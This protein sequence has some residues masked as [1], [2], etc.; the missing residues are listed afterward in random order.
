ML[1]ASVFRL[2]LRRLILLLA[3]LSSLATLGISFYASYQVQRQL[4]IDS[5]LEANRTYA[6]KLADSTEK[7][8]RSAQQQLRFSAA[9]L[10]RQLD[11]PRMVEAEAQR[12]NEQTNSFNSIVITRDDG[13]VLATAPA[14]LEIIG[15]QLASPGALEA[16][17]E[18][19]PMISKPYVSAAGNLVVFISQ[20]IMRDEQYLGYVGGTIYL[21][22]EN[23]LNSLLGEHHYQDGSYLYAVDGDRRLLYH[24]DAARV[25]TIVTNNQ[26]I[27]AVVAGRS[28]SQRV[29]NSQGVDMLAGYAVVPIA[30]WGIVAQRPTASTLVELND[31]M[32]GVL[33]HT[34]F[35]VALVLLCIWALA[36]LI[37]RPLWQLAQG[38]SELDTPDISE[39]I[40][41]VP[42]WYFETAQL[43]RALL[44]GIGL[45][46]QKIGR[47]HQ[48]V[49]TDPL[50][51]L[52]NR[53]GMANA[54]DI[55]QAQGNP[56]AVVALDI[57][58]FKRINDGHGHAAGDAV[59]GQ[60]AELMRSASRSA[61][62]LCRYGGEEFLM[63]LPEADID[64]A[65]LVAERLRECVARMPCIEPVTISI[66]VSICQPAEQSVEQA[67]KAADKALYQ[68]KQRGRNRLVIAED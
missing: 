20:P 43:K 45:L 22:Q 2:D 51:G 15:Q 42:S 13:E 36:R 35:P 38:A 57:D 30:G 12:L 44:L 3:I 18:R 48:D 17:G 50:T 27:D 34:A 39:R 4:L 53:R 47:L 11:A 58:H 37:S 60:V 28:G 1:T 5:T 24:P 7:F 10:A 32:L 49:Q 63:F 26:A 6:A 52:R 8:F 40:R 33:G 31:H 59:I 23:I 41:K 65:V 19:R 25:G 9:Q 21:R 55:L 16:L 66:G 29:I 54:L 64:V 46:E 62:V 61:D 68:A 14:T 67:I 56:F